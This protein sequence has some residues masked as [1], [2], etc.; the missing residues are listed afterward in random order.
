LS[1]LIL[2]SETLEEEEYSLEKMDFGYRKSAIKVSNKIVIKSTFRLP[3][4]KEE[5]REQAEKT[6]KQL[7]KLRLEKQPKNNRTFGSTFKN[8]EDSSHSAGWLLE[9]SGMKEVKS[10]GAMVS[11]EHANWIINTGN[12]TSRDIKKLIATGQ[13]RVLEKFKISLEREVIFLPE[14]M[15]ER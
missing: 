6:L 13:K 4:K 9:K 3:E 15:L 10:G 7:L 8:P 14:D 2:D 5:Q 11:R 12:A 1:A